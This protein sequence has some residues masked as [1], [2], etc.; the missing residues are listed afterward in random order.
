MTTDPVAVA[1]AVVGLVAATLV[2]AVVVG[3]VAFGFTT[4]ALGAVDVVGIA[5]DLP[6]FNAVFVAVVMDCWELLL[7]W[8][9]TELGVVGTGVADLG[10]VG[11]GVM[12]ASRC[13][14]DG[15]GVA[16]RG[17]TVVPTVGMG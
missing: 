11:T 17:D 3:L 10:V 1:V 2:V 4:V 5:G 14:A 9:E 12:A 16:G 8:E 15:M 7:P 6:A 13:A